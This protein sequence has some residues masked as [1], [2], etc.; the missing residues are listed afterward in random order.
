MAE[1]KTRR[2]WSILVLILV[3][4]SAFILPFVLARIFRPT[5][6]AVF[7]ISNLELG[8]AYSVY[9][10]V[11]MISYFFG[12][13]L[14]DRFS[15]RSL[16]GTALLLTGS[17]GIYMATIP[18]LPHLKWLYGFWGFTTIF[19]FWAALIRAT[20]MWGGNTAQG[21]GF[22]ILE[23]G[24]GILA[25][26]MGTILVFVLSAF[27][28]DDP[29]LVTPLLR[30]DAFKMVI[31]VATGFVMAVGLLAWFT[32]DTSEPIQ[33]EKKQL[34]SLPAIGKLI[35]MPTV[36]LQALI[37]ICAYCGYKITD[38]FSLYA[39]DV[40]GFDEVKA[41][42]IGTMTLWTRP[43]IAISAGLLADRIRASRMLVISFGL[44]AVGAVGL[45]S[46]MMTPSVSWLFFVTILTTSAGIFALRGLYFAITREGKIPLAYT[47]T[48]IGIISV[49]GYTPDVFMGPVMGY[50]LDAS[51]GVV[52]HQHVFWLLAG[53]SVVGV[54]LGMLFRKASLNLSAEISV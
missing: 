1:A 53:F 3:G 48:A 52:G 28:P 11:A 44:V 49:V 46:G 22:G 26:G 8:L 29:E 15:V 31:Y 32:L 35:K 39:K 14:A 16:M 17:G 37:I 5:F 27:L 30:E 9:G 41:A 42:A 18:P 54:I 23:G 21:T 12:G 24:R 38:D 34:V 33:T 6:L 45:A 13:P 10:I 50:L 40:M 19:L 7:E 43:V 36:W 47:G 2:V 20:R 4:E 25:A 51:P